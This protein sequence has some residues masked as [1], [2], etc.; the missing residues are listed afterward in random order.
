MNFFLT[1]G[2]ER[3]HKSRDYL[4]FFLTKG[5]SLHKGRDY[6]NFFLTRGE[7]YKTMNLFV[8]FL[9]QEHVVDIMS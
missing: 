3:L 9:P 8:D 2:G 6:L 5:A 4:I 1:R 7:E